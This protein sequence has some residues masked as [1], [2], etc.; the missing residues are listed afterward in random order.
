MT[1]MFSS[2]AKPF[3]EREMSEISWTRFSAYSDFASAEVVHDD[4][5]DVV[6]YLEPASLGSHLQQ[7][8]R[9]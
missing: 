1:G 9:R 7:T 4:K 5:P 8:E 3:N 6:L 2:L